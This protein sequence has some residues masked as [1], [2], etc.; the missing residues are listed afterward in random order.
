MI[1]AGTVLSSIIL[2]LA[3]GAFAGPELSTPNDAFDFGYLPQN[4]V[5]T[6]KFTLKSVGDETLVIERI[7]PGCGCTKVPLE[8]NTLEPGDS[9]IV[10]L[11]FDTQ[12]FHGSMSK[13]AYIYANDTTDRHLIGFYAN[14]V[15]RPESMN[16]I[17]IKPYK[18]DISQ[19]SSKPRTEL[20]FTVTNTSNQPLDLFVVD[21]P[22]DYVTIDLPKHLK[23]GETGTGRIKLTDSAIKMQFEKS[24]TFG[25]TDEKGTRFTIPIKRTI[26]GADQ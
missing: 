19:I 23:A 11:I 9:T 7:K 18:L 8:K 17:T 15:T 14:V 10:E 3:A 22:P 20:D 12:H 5:V 21:Y 2:V 16:P 1:R 13:G 25:V 26:F 24:F 4:S 6:H